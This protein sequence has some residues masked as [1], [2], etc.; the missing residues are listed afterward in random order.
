MGEDKLDEK[1]N[2]MPLI[3]VQLTEDEIK[4]VKVF[5][6]RCDTSQTGYRA[7]C[8]EMEIAGKALW[9]ELENLYPGVS[10]PHANYHHGEGEGFVTYFKEE[11]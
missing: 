1:E 10:V 5:H 11:E 3:K 6:D 8:Q 9:R 4:H 2:K 7:A